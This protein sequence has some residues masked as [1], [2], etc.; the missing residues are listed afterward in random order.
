MFGQGWFLLIRLPKHLQSDLLELSSIDLDISRIDTRTSELAR[1]LALEKLRSA[2]IATGDELLSAHSK[3]ANLEMQQKKT[4]DDLNLVSAR[5]S[6]DEL[7]SK[8]LTSDRDIRAINHELDSLRFRVS[9]LEEQ[10][11]Q[12]LAEIESATEE[13]ERL[14]KDRTKA[15]LELEEALKA[16]DAAALEL[17][18]LR[19]DLEARRAGITAKLPEVVVASYTRKSARG[20]AVGELEGRDCTACRF[21][22]N[23]VAFDSLMSEPED[24]MVTCP[25]CDAFLVR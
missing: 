22:V 10:E 19:S 7:R 23:G 15:A 3:V 16:Q 20:S 24:V 21:A 1:G 13:V 8:E 4:L 9:S 5:I 14:T 25:N 2:L 6:K 12:L 17:S 18:K 11:L